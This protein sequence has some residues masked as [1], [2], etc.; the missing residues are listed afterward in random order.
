MPRNSPT[1]K[2]ES[3]LAEK[4]A[5]LADLPPR[6]PGKPRMVPGPHGGWLT[7]DGAPGHR[8]TGMIKLRRK[9]VR[10]LMVQDFLDLRPRLVD[11]AKGTV[12]IVLG[13]SE[14]EE[15]AERFYDHFVRFLT[16]DADRVTAWPDLD[17][18]TRNAFIDAMKKLTGGVLT[19]KEIAVSV[20][21]ADQ[22]YA[23]EL[24]LR[25]GLGTQTQLTDEEGNSMLPGVLALPELDIVN[26]QRVQREQME[27]A[28]AR[29]EAGETVIEEDE[30][31][32]ITEDIT[33]TTEGED[34]DQPPIVTFDTV[35][36]A[37]VAMI[38]DHRNAS[39]FA[40]PKPPLEPNGSGVTHPEALTA[41]ALG[42]RQRMR[43]REEQNEQNERKD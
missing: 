8:A 35:D 30:L 12:K 15:A 22:R 7:L 43:E 23:M 28:N 24:L 2:S 34:T 19:K 21:V 38:K 5:A 27:R 11:M 20:G 42:K 25:Y 18:P 39:Y 9:F 29:A 14:P 36:P 13:I 26:L 37:L 4:K 40:K 32:Y 16:P 41:L 6:V 17:T 31:E 1:R 3:Y 33:T 10:D